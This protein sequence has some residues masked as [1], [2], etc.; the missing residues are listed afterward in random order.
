MLPLAWAQ[1]APSHPSVL[2]CLCFLQEDDESSQC[3]ADFDLSLPDNGFMSKNE[4]IRSKVSR[5]T[6]RLRKRYPSNNF[7]EFGSRCFSGELSSMGSVLLPVTVGLGVDR[8]VWY[9]LGCADT[10]NDLFHSM[11]R[12]LQALLGRA[13]MGRCSNVISELSLYNSCGCSCATCSP[14]QQSP[15]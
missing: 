6:E 9:L 13:R 7:G 14:R 10:S 2:S 1:C 11:E 3:S 15:A 5:L 4:V 12:M 8:V